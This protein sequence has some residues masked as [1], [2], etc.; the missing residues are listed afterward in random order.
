MTRFRPRRC[1]PV[2]YV[3]LVN[4][5]RGSIDSDWIV[6]VVEGPEPAGVAIRITTCRPAVKF[7]DG[8]SFTVVRIECTMLI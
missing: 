1:V 2:A 3:K 7:M 4:E 8:I 6:V 5:G